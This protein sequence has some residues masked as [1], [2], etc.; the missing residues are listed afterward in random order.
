MSMGVFFTGNW[1][2]LVVRGKICRHVDTL[3][4]RGEAEVVKYGRTS[5]RTRTLDQ[6][7]DERVCTH[8]CIKW[9]VCKWEL[10]NIVCTTASGRKLV[11]EVPAPYITP[12]TKH[13]IYLYLYIHAHIFHCY[14]RKQCMSIGSSGT[15]H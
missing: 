9:L 15:R 10:L 6:R 7:G 8:T 13:Y 4:L 3:G 12:Y 1:P 14:G 2:A 11:S 5:W